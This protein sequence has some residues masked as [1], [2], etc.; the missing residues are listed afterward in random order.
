MSLLNSYFIPHSKFVGKNTI[1]VCNY[2][3]QVDTFFDIFCGSAIDRI[4][5]EPNWKFKM[6]H[7][8]PG[9]F[10]YWKKQNCLELNHFQ[11]TILGTSEPII[12]EL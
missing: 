12:K 4:V 5:P 10:S 9:V 11:S 6:L 2:C 1:L 7:E 8:R 3:V